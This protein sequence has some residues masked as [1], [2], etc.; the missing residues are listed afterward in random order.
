MKRK[1]GMKKY[2]ALIAYNAPCYAHIE[3]EASSDNKAIAIAKRRAKEADGD[4]ESSIEDADEH[5]VVGVTREEDG[6]IIAES[7][8]V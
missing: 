4:Y 7:I 3:F 5:R 1:A 6:E 2:I 8:D